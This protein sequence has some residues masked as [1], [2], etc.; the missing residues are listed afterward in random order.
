MVELL[1]LR[2]HRLHNWRLREV[3]IWPFLDLYDVEEKEFASRDS[4]LLQMEIAVDVTETG[5][6]TFHTHAN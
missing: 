1:S 6:R 5:S 2:K 4:L 3:Q